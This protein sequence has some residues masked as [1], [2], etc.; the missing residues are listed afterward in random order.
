MT[1]SGRSI[2]CRSIF[3]QCHL[4]A[5]NQ[6]KKSPEL[7]TSG[8]KGISF[9]K[10][11]WGEEVYHGVQN[12]ALLRTLNWRLATSTLL[13]SDFVL[14]ILIH[15]FNVLNSSASAKATQL[16]QPHLSGASRSRE[17]PGGTDLS[18]TDSVESKM[19]TGQFP[20]LVD[21]WNNDH[22]PATWRRKYFQFFKWQSG[23]KEGHVLERNLM[24]K[25]YYRRSTV[26]QVSCCLLIVQAAD[27]TCPD[28]ENKPALQATGWE[29]THHGRVVKYNVSL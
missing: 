2:T 19:I 3:Y 12:R 24:M 22:G 16:H 13:S 11:H 21:P 9:P 7:R 17:A 25:Q 23:S 10:S 27:W 6:L 26:V 5:R 28:P 4:Q 1:G 20:S 8:H 18:P 15:Q 29:G 14:I